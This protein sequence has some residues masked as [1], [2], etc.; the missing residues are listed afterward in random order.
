MNLFTPLTWN[1]LTLPSRVFLAPINTGFSANSLPTER[2]TEFHRLRSGAAIGLS[3]VGNV[4]VHPDAVSNATNCV[5]VNNSSVASFSLVAKAIKDN[6]SAAGIQLAHA[7]PN[8][9]PTRK[10]KAESITLESETL[11]ST[12]ANIPLRQLDEHISR[13]CKSAALAC[14]AGFDVVQIH[15][16]HGYLLSLLLNGDFNPR[17]DKYSVD[18]SWLSDFIERLRDAVP[19]PKWLSFRINAAYLPDNI[20]SQSRVAQELSQK[21]DRS[22]VDF[23][24][25]S[26]GVYNIDRNL[27]YPRSREGDAPPY[28]SV[29]TRI[30]K[31]ASAVV[32]F[33]GQASEFHSYQHLLGPL[34]VVSI[35]RPLI[36]DPSFATKVKDGTLSTIRH[37][38]FKGHCHYFSRGKDFLECGVNAE[39]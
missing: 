19:R 38:A 21:L 20:D 34:T 22:G 26:A 6:G 7:T 17:R 11:K 9:V 5:L 24:D 39:L 14:K 10:W 32:G 3:M 15:A 33:A 23:I 4:A 35:G 29:A 36:A 25:I 37:C 8:I 16:A 27:I 1:G 12:I 28:L 18:G 13:F 2:L 31:H 30:A